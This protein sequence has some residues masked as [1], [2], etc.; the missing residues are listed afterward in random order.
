MHSKK[1]LD[2]L[3]G[4]TQ[5]LGEQFRFFQTNTCAAF[6]TKE[7]QWEADKRYRNKTRNGAPGSS[8]RKPKSFNLNTYKFHALG[9][10][11]ETIR[12]YGTTD[13][14]STEPVSLPSACQF[15][16][17]V[18]IH[19][20]RENSNIVAQK[21]AINGLQKKTSRDNWHKSSAGGHG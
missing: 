9:D 14:Y 11:V 8:K 19:C 7:L 17:V 18:V 3:D 15:A 13:S 12:M 20:Y 2:I 5:T 10:Y 6:E 21:V 4:Q 16:N 1:T